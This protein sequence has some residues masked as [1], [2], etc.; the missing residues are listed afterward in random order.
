MVDTGSADL[1]CPRVRQGGCGPGRAQSGAQGYWSLSLRSCGGMEGGLAVHSRGLGQR[2]L[3]SLFS[4][5]FFFLTTQIHVQ[6]S[7]RFLSTTSKKHPASRRVEKKSGIWF[8][9]L[10]PLFSTGH[11]SPLSE[12]SAFPEVSLSDLRGGRRALPHPPGGAEL[13]PEQVSWPSWVIPRQKFDP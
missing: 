10:K 2:C 8:A 4:L 1:L 9:R 7:S 3:L 13:K 6:P 12:C 11:S 5:F